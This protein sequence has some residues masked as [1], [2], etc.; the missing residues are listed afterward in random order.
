M[1][2]SLNDKRSRL[3]NLCEGPT[4]QRENQRKREK[5]ERADAYADLVER[6]GEQCMICGFV[7]N[8]KRRLNVDHCHRTKQLRGLLCYRCNYGLHWF[9]DDSELLHNA[10]KYMS[11]W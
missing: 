1:S 7:P 11:R 8:E 10:G 2:R 3:C 6:F 9:R 5:Q 4:K